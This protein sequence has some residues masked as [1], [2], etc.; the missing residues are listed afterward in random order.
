MT[1]GSTTTAT[2]NSSNGGKQTFHT[3]D[4]FFGSLMALALVFRAT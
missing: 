1:F 2:R 3:A 4:S